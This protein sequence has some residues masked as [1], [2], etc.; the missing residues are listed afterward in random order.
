MS[1]QDKLNKLKY[2]L[3]LDT[4]NLRNI[5]QQIQSLT[6]YEEK[7]NYN[8]LNTLLY[9]EKSRGCRIPSTIPIPT[10][11]FQL[12]HTMQLSTNENGCFLG[13]INPYFLSTQKCWGDMYEFEYGSN[14][15]N[16]F[17]REITGFAF[18][19]AGGLDGTTPLGDGVFFNNTDIQT[20][21]DVYSKYR[22]VSASLNIKYIG[23]L[24]ECSGLVGGAIV[25]QQ[26]GF[27]TG[28]FAVRTTDITDYDPTWAFYLPYYPMG[29]YGDFNLLRRCV[30]SNE[31]YL[32]EGL[33]MLYFPVDNSYNEFIPIYNGN[34]TSVVSVSKTNPSIPSVKVTEDAVRT[35]FN[36]IFYIEH[37]QANTPTIMLDLCFNY[38][39]IPK[40]EYLEYFDV[41][42]CLTKLSLVER[43]NIINEIKNNAIK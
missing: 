36:W 24:T 23:A 18:S 15:R 25:T 21:E 9:P 11:T 10:C 40:A 28:R 20:I 33:R 5:K 42:T 2:S 35:G 29:Q 1:L 22:L 37:A 31:N 34:G 27:M 19:R 13:I 6:N 38:E 16:V 12:K 26:V 17:L 3:N 43:A 41:G 8:Y 14:K 7:E 30:Y 32:V 39:C 4:I